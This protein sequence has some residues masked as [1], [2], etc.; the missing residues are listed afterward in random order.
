MEGTMTGKV[1]A[2]DEMNMAEF[3][4]CGVRSRELDD[5]GKFIVYQGSVWDPARKEHV[6]RELI[7]EGSA[8]FGLPYGTDDDVLLACV[9]LSR[10]E[11][12]KSR[13]ISF[14]AYRLLKELGWSD[15]GERFERL[16]DGLRRWSKIRIHSERHFWDHERQCFYDEDFG[17]IDTLR[18]PRSKVEK[19]ELVWSDGFWRSL[20]SGYV[21]SLNWE[22]YLSLSSHVAK[23]LYRLLDKRFHRE[24]QREF[25]FDLHELAVRHVGLSEGKATTNI[26]RE[27]LTGIRELEEKWGRVQAVPPN[28][29]FRKVAKGKWEVVFERSSRLVPSPEAATSPT[30]TENGF[31]EKLVA[32][33]VTD[34]VA[35]ELTTSYPE[36]RIAEKLELQDWLMERK[37]K[38][39]EK[40]PA[41]YLVAAIRDDYTPP[42]GFESKAVREA[43]RQA[44]AERKAKAEA[45]AKAVEDQ[46]EKAKLE[47]ERPLREYL[48]RLTPEEQT[49]L[50]RDAVEWTDSFKRGLYQQAKTSGKSGSYPMYRE[51]ILF[52]YIE[53]KILNLLPSAKELAQNE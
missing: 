51:M 23:R 39:I 7:I 52:D 49:T 17:V 29:R 11:G 32:Y 2:K 47:R 16:R 37:D 31:A 1:K 8:K 48:E 53:R 41:G 24:K 9:K 30:R 45:R 40:N 46:R 5:E 27:L 15:G 6:R 28:E 43:K 38:R 21:K 36:E 34:K 22:L 35:A 19:W 4:L 18:V 50:E 42:K 12:F 13:R 26:K 3:A 25:R 44:A 10:E 33:G 20:R 14:S